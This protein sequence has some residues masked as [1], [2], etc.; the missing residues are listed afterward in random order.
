MV[1]VD[2]FWSYGIGASM[3]LAAG[4]QLRARRE[5]ARAEPH[6][7]ADRLSGDP[8]DRASPWRNPFFL[9]AVLFAALLFAPSGAY[10]LWE[11]PDWETMHAADRDVASWLVAL[12]AVTNVTQAML[13]FWVVERLIARGRAYAAYLQVVAAYLAM[14]FVLVHGWDGEGYRRFFSPD[15]AD[16]LAWSGD[17]TR[18]LTSDVALTLLAM[19][20]V[21]IPVLLGTIARWTVAGYPLAPPEAVRPGAVA[22][23]AI[24]LTT[25]FGAALGIAVAVSL[26]VHALGV[27]GAAAATALAALALVP[28]GPVHRLFGLL[29]LDGAAPAGHGLRL[30]GQSSFAR[31]VL[32]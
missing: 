17:W 2:V 23:I 14:F 28:G 5:L 25:V 15:R 22:V 32:G 18:W 9:G 19:G 27:T 4:R 16:Y 3:A 1:Q 31:R 29:G 26:L 10:L 11:F 8:A 7:T 21:L 24:H 20:A 30:A 13:G 12:F 6:G